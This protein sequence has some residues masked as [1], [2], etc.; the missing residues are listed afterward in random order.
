VKH[1]VPTVVKLS[2]RPYR[3]AYH[4][5]PGR[6]DVRRR[7]PVYPGINVRDLKRELYRI[8][9]GRDLLGRRGDSCRD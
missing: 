3:F 6:S 1:A 2:D 9:R 7:V 5:V 4:R 8:R